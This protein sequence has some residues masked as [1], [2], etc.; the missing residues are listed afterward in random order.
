MLKAAT[1]D[2]VWKGMKKSDP[3]LIY[4][5]QQIGDVLEALMLDKEVEVKSTGKGD[6][7]NVA[8]GKICYRTVQ[9]SSGAH[10]GGLAS[11]PCAVCPRLRDCTPDGI[12]SPR[13]C[14]YY[15]KWFGVDL[16]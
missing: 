8:A 15:K 10:I 3:N 9:R 12:I 13:N 5:A 4:T 16:F 6:F 7:V 1:S 11:V 14:E 2:M